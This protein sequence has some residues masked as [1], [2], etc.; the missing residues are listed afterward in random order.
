MILEEGTKEEKKP[1]LCEFFVGMP[2]GH[3]QALNADQ[4]IYLFVKNSSP[5]TGALMSEIYETLKDEDGSGRSEK[6]CLELQHGF[7]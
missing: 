7:K 2:L 1:T 6:P 4:T 5:K 3:H